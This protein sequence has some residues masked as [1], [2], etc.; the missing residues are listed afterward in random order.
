MVTLV[1]QLL[2]TYAMSIDFG[3]QMLSI[4]RTF[5]TYTKGKKFLW[6]T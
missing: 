2:L 4:H 1:L 3:L 6:L 5:C